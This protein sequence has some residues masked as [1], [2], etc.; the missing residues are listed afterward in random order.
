MFPVPA[1]VQD[2]R[3]RLRSGLLKSLSLIALITLPATAFCVVFA[4][5]L[6]DL[7]LGDN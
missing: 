4:D 3:A 7:L 5:E 2:D 6:V 1:Q